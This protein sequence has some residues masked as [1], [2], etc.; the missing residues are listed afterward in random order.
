MPLCH[1]SGD[2]VCFMADWEL[3]LDE[4]A[5]TY[6]PGLKRA[7]WLVHEQQSLVPNIFHYSS[8]HYGQSITRNVAKAGLISAYRDGDEVVRRYVHAVRFFKLILYTA[9]S[10]SHGRSD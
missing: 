7:Y 10:R 6:F 8:F 3:A 9:G 4:P 5:R 2:L 1:V